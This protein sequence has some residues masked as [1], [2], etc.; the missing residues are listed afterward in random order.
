MVLVPKLPIEL[1]NRATSAFGKVA[2]N[3]FQEAVRT[4]YAENCN[5]NRCMSNVQKRLLSNSI[6]LVEMP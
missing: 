6:E 3:M 2:M 1:G 5:F 4:K